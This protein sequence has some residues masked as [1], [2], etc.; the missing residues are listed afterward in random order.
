MSPRQPTGSRAHS[1]CAS[2]TNGKAHP[3][4][5]TGYM[6]GFL[7][8]QA[9]AAQRLAKAYTILGASKLRKSVK[10]QRAF[11][12]I[13]ATTYKGHN[14]FAYSGLLKYT[15]KTISQLPVYY[16]YQ[17]AARGAEGCTKTSRGA[18]R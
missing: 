11:W 17:K 10:L 14:E 8:T 13:G 4:Y 16:A 9:G 18:C 5:T 6:S 7:T 15:S 12:Y 3:G 1:V 2:R